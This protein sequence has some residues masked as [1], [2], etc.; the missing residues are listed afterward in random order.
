MTTGTTEWVGLPSPRLGA[1]SSCACALCRPGSFTPQ[2]VEQFRARV[3][4]AIDR[5]ADQIP[6]SSARAVLA[7]LRGVVQIMEPAG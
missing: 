3:L 7:R 6:L 4:A 5:E 1:G 2:A